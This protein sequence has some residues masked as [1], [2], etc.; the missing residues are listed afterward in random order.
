MSKWFKAFALGMQILTAIENVQ[1][2]TPAT[3][4]VEWKSKLYELTLK[5]TPIKEV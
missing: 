1:A 3:I 5:Q 4:S 2:G